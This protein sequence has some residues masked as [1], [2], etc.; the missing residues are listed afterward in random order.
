ML[1]IEEIRK[2]KEEYHITNAQLANLS[3]VPFATVQKVLGNVTKS[4]RLETI[5]A[6]S[7]VFEE[8]EPIQKN[9]YETEEGISLVSEPEAA[10][11]IPH[12]P[13]NPALKWKVDAT[14]SA[15]TPE[16]I[17]ISADERQRMSA[18]FSQWRR[19]CTRKYSHY[20]RW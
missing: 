3:G 9:Y 5:K 2:K 12:Y 14:S 10:Y 15:A 20:F 16:D 13:M 11:A 8:K 6:L 7:K 4:P 1:T 18:R 17:V 19:N